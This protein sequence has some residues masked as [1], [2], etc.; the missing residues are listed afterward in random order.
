MMN[1]LL[2]GNLQLSRRSFLELGSAAI[3]SLNADSVT[4]DAKAAIDP[5]LGEAIS[6]LQYLTPLD[7]A[8]ILDKGKTGIS[9][10]PP[11][12]IKEIGLTPE[13]WRL[14]VVADPSSNCIVE[15]SFSRADGNALNWDRLMK[16]AEKT[17]SGFFTFSTVPMVLIRF[18]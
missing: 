7:R 1:D 3:A 9:K 10:M 8:I 17:P 15:Q 5:H 6:K 18:I 2:P 11:E 14:E 13:T 16:L 4:Y 12:K